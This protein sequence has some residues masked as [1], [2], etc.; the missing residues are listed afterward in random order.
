MSNPTDNPFL[1][2]EHV[3]ASQPLY[4]APVS[5][6]KAQGTIG[7]EYTTDE[8]MPDLVKEEGRIVD[9]AMFDKLGEVEIARTSFSISKFH[10]E[11]LTMPMVLPEPFSL[12][13]TDHD[14]SEDTQLTR[15]VQ[16]TWK[17][18]CCLRLRRELQQPRPIWIYHRQKHRE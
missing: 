9:A 14:G 4:S 10:R 8:D 5:D 2:K 12:P 3:A 1:S 11:T 18:P 16:S 7:A 15:S 17:K 13:F 6:L